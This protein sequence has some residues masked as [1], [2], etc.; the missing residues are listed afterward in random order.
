MPRNGRW[1]RQIHVVEDE[2]S[3]GDGLR[4][5]GRVRLLLLIVAGEELEAKRVLMLVIEWSKAKWEAL[6]RWCAHRIGEHD[7]RLPFE[8]LDLDFERVRRRVDRRGLEGQLG[9]LVR[10]RNPREIPTLAT[11][12]Q[13]RR[14]DWERSCGRCFVFHGQPCTPRD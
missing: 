14:D 4:L 2:A 6:I 5:I 3:G 11:F 7:E 9:D 10:D 8:A 12:E 13:G 1:R